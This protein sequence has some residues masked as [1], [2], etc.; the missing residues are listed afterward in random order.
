M[1]L[2]LFPSRTMTGY[3]A[4]LFAVR[5]VAVLVMLVLVLQMLNLLSESG[6]ILAV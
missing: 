4:R 6:H 1:V 3:I 5:I 2:D